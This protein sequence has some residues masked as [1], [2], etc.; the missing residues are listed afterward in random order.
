MAVKKN[1]S[2]DPIEIRGSVLARNA[3]F[4]LFGLGLPLIIAV[5]TIPVLI[6]YM[7]KERFGILA[8]AWAIFGYLSIFDI[9]LVQATTRYVAESLGKGERHQVPKFLWT[10]VVFQAMLGTAGALSLILATPMLV[11]RLLHIP[12]VLRGEAST[13]FILIALSL[14]I[15]LIS[16]SFRGSLE[17]GQ[18]FDLVNAVKIPSGAASNLFPLIG[19][20]LGFNLPGIVLL[21]LCSR[22]LTLLAWIALCFRIYP[23]VRDTI[24]FH[25]KSVRP[26]L[27]FGS[28][29]TVSSFLSPFLTYL[30]RFMI[31]ALLTV[32]AVS[33]YAAPYE[34]T[35]RLGILPG[36]MLMLLFP[37]FSALRG[38]KD[39]NKTRS[40]FGRSF[41]YILIG[42]GPIIVL[43]IVFAKFILNLWIGKD[44]AQ[45]SSIVL[46]ILAGGYLLNA[47]ANISVGFLLGMGRSDIPAKF[48]ILEVLFYIPLL[49]LLIRA[50]GIQGAALAWSIRVTV[51]MILLF[52]AAKRVG[53]ASF[54][55][56]SQFQIIPVVA[57][58]I[59]FAII[60]FSIQRIFHGWLSM[61]PVLAS[62]GFLIWKFAFNAEERSWILTRVRNVLRQ[63]S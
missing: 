3:I 42:I 62:L 38:R 49:W 45:H 9:G 36:S 61:I 28:W 53:G 40:L 19:A 30:D 7:G 25:R 55:Q 13:V 10:T 41:K 63:R 34:M 33:Y 4:N 52:L 11:N 15:S 17:A 57:T 58:L 47:L 8:L 48:H 12:P 37:A 1:A 54:P 46:Q 2:A 35:V 31:G 29:I 21:I 56:L 20:L 39:E 16:G 18:R 6:N 26:L 14:P 50:K 43:I 51:D 24:S 32:T 59:S 44:F 27:K 60:S 22:V 23:E 5:V